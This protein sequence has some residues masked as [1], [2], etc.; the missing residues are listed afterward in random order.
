M[1]AL[2]ADATVQLSV[3]LPVESIKSE[4]KLT[5]IIRVNTSGMYLCRRIYYIALVLLGL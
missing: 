5:S 3:L 2:C 4:L 1:L